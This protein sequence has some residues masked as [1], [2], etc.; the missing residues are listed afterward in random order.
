MA[1]MPIAVVLFIFHMGLWLAM[2][3]G[4]LFSST[5]RQSFCVLSFIVVIFIM[6][7]LLRHMVYEGD[8]L[9]RLFM[10]FI[11]ESTESV[12]PQYFEETLIGFI[13]TLQLFRTY[14]IYFITET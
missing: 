1:E 2:I 3:Y 10:E 5:F 6:Y 9:T 4:T 13:L 14:F 12:K 11:L 8:E 7:R